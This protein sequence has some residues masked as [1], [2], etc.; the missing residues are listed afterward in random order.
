MLR[1]TPILLVACTLVLAVLSKPTHII[2]I[3]A[4]GTSCS[5]PP[6][7]S[8]GCAVLQTSGGPVTRTQPLLY[9][10]SLASC[11]S[12]SRASTAR[13]SRA[14]PTKQLPRPLV[15]GSL[16]GFWGSDVGYHS[17]N[18]SAVEVLTPNIDAAAAAGIELDRMY[19]H[20]I[21]S[22]S[23]CSIQTG[24]CCCLSVA[25]CMGLLLPP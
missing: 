11:E 5:L 7:P 10:H 12:P 15:P 23:R 4:D 9:I 22:P 21:C 8:D 24:A 14:G 13:C 19:V 17:T 16:T 1:V 18:A 6:C 25:A 2:H 3:L 20:K